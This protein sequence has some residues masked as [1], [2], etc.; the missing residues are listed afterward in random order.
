MTAG[1]SGKEYAVDGFHLLAQPHI[2]RALTPCYRDAVLS[3]HGELQNEVI[4]P[5]EQIT[6]QEVRAICPWPLRSA[7]TRRVTAMGHGVISCAPFLPQ[8]DMGGESSANPL[9]RQAGAD[10]DS[11]QTSPQAPSKSTFDITKLSMVNEHKD[12]ENDLVR[13]TWSIMMLQSNPSPHQQ[14]RVAAP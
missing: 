3:E 2:I 5:F 7:M 13:R 8:V 10:S 4:T 9:Q 12:D 14:L 11:P 6:R 1:D